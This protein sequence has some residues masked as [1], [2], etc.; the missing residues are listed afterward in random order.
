M[1]P[2]L[3]VNGKRKAVITWPPIIVKCIISLTLTFYLE[4]TV[5]LT[6]KG[7]PM[8]TEKFQLTEKEPIDKSVTAVS[9]AKACL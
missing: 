9:R 4:G 8:T 5:A 3:I 2:S 1:D 6:A 7:T